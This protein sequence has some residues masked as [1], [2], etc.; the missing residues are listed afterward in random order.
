M[1]VGRAGFTVGTAV[2]VAVTLAVAGCG[3]T[4]STPPPTGPLAEAVAT[5]G[6]GGAH[7][8]LGIGW[9]DPQLVAETSAGAELIGD[10]LGPNAR[11]VIE[12]APRLRRRFG[13]D[14]L[15]AERLVSV[16]GSYA[17][18]LRLDGVDGQRL[19]QR[20][21]EAG[22]RARRA[23]ELELVDIGDYAVV[24]E[25]LLRSGVFGLGARDAFSRNLT[26]LAISETARDALLGRGDRLLDEPT[27]RAAAG[28]LGDVIAARLIPDNLLLST[29]LG[30]DLVA[31]GVS[32]AERE[33]L[34]VLG[35]TAERAGEVASALKSSLAPNAREPVTREPI[36]DSVAAA[37]VVRD[38][39]EG[40][41]V[42]R[43]KLTL[44]A[45]QSPGFLFGAV[46]RGSLVG[47]INGS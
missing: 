33:V 4:P 7:G 41:E 11:S 6:G 17:F 13:F 18:G 44:A 39:Y 1:P 30:V 3:D 46:S 5:V 29:D 42:V 24:P 32:K 34:C 47:L 31:L 36:S 35:G 12:E 19:G 8:L 23:G 37:E 20:L 27:Y 10:A 43:A 45:G 2:V 16:G 21:V 15:T 25:P 40:V 22:G 38:R 26:V 14:P 9:A 28:C